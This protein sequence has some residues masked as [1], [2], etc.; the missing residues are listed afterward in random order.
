MPLRRAASRLASSTVSTSIAT[1]SCSMYLSS[2]ASLNDLVPGIDGPDEI[3]DTLD[4]MTLKILANPVEEFAP[5]ER[6]DEIGGPDLNGRGA[7]DHEFE[8]VTS[9]GDAAHADDR[10]FDGFAALVD[11][12]H[13]DRPNRWTAEAAHAI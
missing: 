3:R 10:N 9:I 1:S 11:H 5:D 8:R 7:G 6:I 13:G 2:L 4:V 12:P